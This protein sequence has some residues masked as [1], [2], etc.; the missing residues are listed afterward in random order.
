MARMHSP[1]IEVE[2][3]GMRNAEDLESAILEVLAAIQAGPDNPVS[4]LLV[5]SSLIE[6][7][8]TQEQII[9]RLYQMEEKKQ[10]GLIGG[11]RLRLVNPLP[12]K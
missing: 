3:V 4:L 7:G 1:R 11:N 9:N 8:F 10:I 5:G 12:W 6:Q 2:G